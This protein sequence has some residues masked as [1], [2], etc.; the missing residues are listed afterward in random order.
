MNM[1]PGDTG[2]LPLVPGDWYPRLACGGTTAHMRALEPH[3]GS[4]W[5][6]KCLETQLH[7]SLSQWLNPHHLCVRL[8]LSP[9]AG[10]PHSWRTLSNACS[11]YLWYSALMAL[12]SVPPLT[13]HWRLLHGCM[14][15]PHQATCAD[16]KSVSKMDFS[17][18]GSQLKL[19]M[20][21]KS[22]LRHSC[23]ICTNKP[24]PN[25]QFDGAVGERERGAYCFPMVTHQYLFLSVSP[26]WCQGE[27]YLWDSMPVKAAGCSGH[28]MCL[29]LLIHWV[30]S[31]VV[32]CP[33]TCWWETVYTGCWLQPAFSRSV[34][35][36][37]RA[38]T[39]FI[40][41]LAGNFCQSDFCNWIPS[42]LSEGKH[43]DIK[44]EECP[45][46]AECKTRLR[47]LIHGTFITNCN[48]QEAAS[49]FSF[50]FLHAGFLVATDPE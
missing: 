35:L 24:P 50:P 46:I 17:F 34:L 40:H 1:T 2:C 32:Q 7:T 42:F 38:S 5:F 6:S 16:L 18:R 14:C 48:P 37:H 45:S 41:F 21:Q 13:A 44:E 4:M 28:A 20:C 10:V 23:N 12:V 49:C 29:P 11:R 43:V 15:H 27:N 19:R 47:S 25:S 39:L 8:P 33:F 22:G 26:V 36:F 31:A 30:L 3:K 9:S